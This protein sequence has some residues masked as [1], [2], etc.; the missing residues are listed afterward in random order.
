MAFGLKLVLGF[1]HSQ[2][3]DRTERDLIAI[4]NCRARP[5]AAPQ[6]RPLRRGSAPRL[7]DKGAKKAGATLPGLGNA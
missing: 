2:T 1:K 6:P 3:E 7:N 4:W 5:P